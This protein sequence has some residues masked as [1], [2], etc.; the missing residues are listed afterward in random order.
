MA[1]PDDGVILDISIR[2]KVH[3]EQMK[4]SPTMATLDPLD[5]AKELV[6]NACIN[7]LRWITGVDMDD[8]FRV[9]CKV[10]GSAT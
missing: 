8:S 5:R 6:K 3:P 2:V 4:Y 9:D 10:V 7:D 1:C